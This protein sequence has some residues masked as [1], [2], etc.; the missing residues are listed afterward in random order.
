MTPVLPDNTPA[1]REFHSRLQSA[2][3]LACSNLKLAQ[4]RQKFYADRTRT[5]SPFKRGD[6]VL[7]DSKLYHFDELSKHKLN[8][9]WYGPLRVIDATS[10]T[11]KLRTPLDK[12]F[13]CK[14]HASACK[15]Y[16]RPDVSKPAPLLDSQTDADNWERK[17]IVGH[18]R[19]E[20]S[21]CKE[22][23]VRFMHPPHNVPDKD[24]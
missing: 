11:V 24:E 5:P 2:L 22:F 14:A 19:A 8:A 18:K 17:A 7:L 13:F 20:N 10:E 15:L 4:A 16:V 21:R 6:E 3:E 9:K 1:G 23:R 12:D